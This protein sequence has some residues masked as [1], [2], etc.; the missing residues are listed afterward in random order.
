MLVE[1]SIHNR[2]REVDELHLLKLDPQV[3]SVP[4]LLRKSQDESAEQLASVARAVADPG[5]TDSFRIRLPPGRYAALCRVPVGTLP[6]EDLS[7]RMVPELEDMVFDPNS[8]THLRRGMYGQ[9]T[10]EAPP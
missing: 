6:G 2:D 4:Q 5:K 3:R 7:A 10:V 9:L 1:F 8:D